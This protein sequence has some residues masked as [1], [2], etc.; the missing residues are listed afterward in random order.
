MKFDLNGFSAITPSN[1]KPKVE[2]KKTPVKIN[3]SL[4]SVC[5]NVKC[6]LHPAESTEINCYV[7][8]DPIQFSYYTMINGEICNLT[9]SN[10]LEFKYI[11]SSPSNYYYLAWTSHPNV[12]KRDTVYLDNN[13]NWKAIP[14]GILL[15]VSIHSDGKV[16]YIKS[17][18]IHDRIERYIKET[19]NYEHPYGRKVP[20]S[21]RDEIFSRLKNRI[22]AD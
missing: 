14:D 18:K 6:T 22:Y 19:P 8:Y 4:D 20:K 16:G 9:I 3:R 13:N 10:Y 12:R 2:R 5:K 11:F 17:D 15:P 21:V 7:Y 1:A